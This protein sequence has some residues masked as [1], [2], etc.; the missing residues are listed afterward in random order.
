MKIVVVGVGKV[1]LKLVETL[2]KENHEIYVVDTDGKNVN[3]VVNKYDVMGVVGSGCERETLLDATADKADFFIACTSRDELNILCCVL[4]KKLGAKYAVARVREPSYSKEVQSFADDLGID[5]SFNPEYTTAMEISK[6]LKFPF[7]TVVE[8]FSDD[9]ADLVE[10][11]IVTGNPI[12]GMSVMGIA[13]EYGNNLLFAIVKRGEKV[14]IPKGDFVIREDDFVSVLGTE[15]EISSFIKKLHLYKRSSKSVFI[16]GGGMIA[17]YLAEALSASGIDVK[18]MEKDE[19]RCSVLSETLPKANVLCGDGTDKDV[20]DEEDLKDTDAF[21][22][23]TGMDEE[24]V[25]VSLYALG[26]KVS[27]VVTKVDRPSVVSITKNLGLDTVVS[28]R[29]VIA[30]HVLRFVRAHQ[31]SATGEGVDTLY[32]IDDKAEAIEFTVGEN[33][34]KLGVPIKNLRIK[35]E[36]LIGGIIRDGKF[37]K[38][39]GDSTFSVGDK[40]I[41]ISAIKGI[42]DLSGALN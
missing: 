26:L 5:M 31:A 25:I 12:I 35:D 41:V 13:K 10:F 3:S 32:K 33:F 18:I 27:K 11:K 37:L 7:A 16:V 22:A 2:S 29:T 6:V 19:D 1:G 14:F 39:G 34:T 40:V 36:V 24:N 30:N 20:L 15:T 4:A 38:A 9:R 28:P 21:V 42:T 23:L 8:K 17:F